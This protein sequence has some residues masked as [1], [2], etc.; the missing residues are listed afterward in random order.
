MTGL[1]ATS[2]DILVQADGYEFGLISE[3][4]DHSGV[5]NVH[6]GAIGS[7]PLSVSGPSAVD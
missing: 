3:F 2:Y 7:N 4:Y 5:A 6:D 1:S